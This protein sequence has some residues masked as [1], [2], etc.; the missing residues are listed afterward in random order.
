[1]SQNLVSSIQAKL[2]ALEEEHKLRLAAAEKRREAAT[3][4]IDLIVRTVQGL[5]SPYLEVWQSGSFTDE[6]VPNYPNIEVAVVYRS[7]R[8]VAWTLSPRV[9]VDPL[10]EDE[11]QNAIFWA[12]DKLKG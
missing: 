11:I 6:N 3:A 10:S 4:K 8:L 7:D 1:M 2:A 9:Y 12:L 5:N